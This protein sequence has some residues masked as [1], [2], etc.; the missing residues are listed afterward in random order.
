MPPGVAALSRVIPVRQPSISRDSLQSRLST[1]Q[2][3]VCFNPHRLFKGPTSVNDRL[4]SLGD[5]SS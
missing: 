5:V 2:F 3:Y 1:T 4:I